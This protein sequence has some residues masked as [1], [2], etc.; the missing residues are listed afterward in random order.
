MTASGRSPEF[1][2][3]WTAGGLPPDAVKGI[4]P[5]VKAAW[6][7]A[8]R[9]GA[10]RIVGALAYYSLGD[11]VEASRGYLLDYY[12]L[13]GDETAEWIAGAA[14]RTAESIKGALGAYE[15]AGVDE[16]ILD[17]TVSDPS[18]VDLLAEVV[19]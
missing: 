5:K 2:V 8:G 9:E 7:E 12:A 14:L 1:G 18:Q 16:L 3:G 11:T 10:P 17:P 4:V 6:S 19:F 13:L 15:D